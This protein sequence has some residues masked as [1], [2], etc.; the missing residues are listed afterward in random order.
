LYQA[1]KDVSKS[2][3]ALGDLLESIEHFLKRLDI[4]T[5]LPAESLSALDEI[6]V[7]II[8]SLLSTLALA[9]RQIK[10]GRLSELGPPDT[11]L[12]DGSM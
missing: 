1:T 6:V 7:K 2:Y 4:Y 8:A 9:T 11:S 12:N 10:E 5:K 3:D